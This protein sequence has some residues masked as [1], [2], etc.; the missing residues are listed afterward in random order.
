M[1]LCYL[2]FLENSCG[3]GVGNASNNLAIIFLPR[4]SASHSYSFWI[5][6]RHFLCGSFHSVFGISE[7]SGHMYY[8]CTCYTT[9]CD[10]KLE[11]YT[12]SYTHRPIYIC[13]TVYYFIW[14]PRV[15]KEKPTIA[16]MS[17]RHIWT[18]PWKTKN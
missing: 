1:V 18:S 7:S 5:Q 10:S 6:N 11:I 8:L 17:S 3:T 12:L 2:D 9:S 13:L 4:T 14:G 16:F 15:L